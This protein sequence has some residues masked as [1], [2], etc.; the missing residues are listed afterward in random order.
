MYYKI[1]VGLQ[2]A[3]LELARPR[4]ERRSNSFSSFEMKMRESI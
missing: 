3:V 1:N 2:A 4:E